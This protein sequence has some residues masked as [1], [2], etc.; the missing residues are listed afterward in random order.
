MLSKYSRLINRRVKRTFKA[1]TNFYQFYKA[2]KDDL[3]IKIKVESL[4]IFTS[5]SPGSNDLPIKLVPDDCDGYR[6][7]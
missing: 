3:N 1:Q 7:S 4:K 6:T 5:T 2:C